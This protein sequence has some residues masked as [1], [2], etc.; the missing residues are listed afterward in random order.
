MKPALTHN[1][2]ISATK[3]FCNQ[4]HSYPKLFGVTDGKAIGTF[5]EHTF[6]L[7]LT[8]FYEVQTGSSA[9]GLDL[10]ALETDIK[11]TS[12]RQPQSSCPFRSARQKCTVWDITS[13]CLCMTNK[14]IQWKKRPN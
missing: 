13:S 8:T 4:P 5:I 7:H 3:A 10:P 12:I 14:I 2:L 11:V 9:L 6:Q 1:A